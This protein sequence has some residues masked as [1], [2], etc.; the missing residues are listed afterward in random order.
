MEQVIMECVEELLVQ[1]FY[2]LGLILE[3]QLWE[4][5]KLQELKYIIKGLNLSN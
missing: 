5:N 1:D 2:I 4:E 3:L